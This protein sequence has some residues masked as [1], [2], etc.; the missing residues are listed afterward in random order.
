[1]EPPRNNLTN[2]LSVLANFLRTLF[3]KPVSPIVNNNLPITKPQ[4]PTPQIQIAEAEP[5]ITQPPTQESASTGFLICPISINDATGN[6]LTSKT[7]KISAII[8]HSG[9]A[10]D[11]SSTNHWGIH[12]KDQ[13]V[14]AFNGEIG[15]GNQCPQEPCGYQKNDSSEFFKDKEINYVGVSSDGGKYT[16]QYDGHAGYDFPYPVLTPVIAPA[17]GELYKATPG[18]DLI[19]NG[20]WGKD[21]SFY[22]KHENGFVTWFRHCKKLAD[23]IEAV[24][25]DDLNKNCRVKSG[26]PVAFSGDFESSE[27]GGTKP[28][29]HFEVQDKNGKIV[30][31]YAEKLWEI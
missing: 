11:P 9:T 22:I 16:L 4:T 12:A 20:H 30:D 24:I 29:L 10:I 26:D 5:K 2:L 19:Y 23:N 21:H 18:T 14:K 27:P 25:G 8:D 15:E 28:H 17:A 1:M 7:V 31:P 3:S 13:K 6:P